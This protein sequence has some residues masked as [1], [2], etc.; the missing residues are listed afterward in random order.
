[1]SEQSPD[2]DRQPWFASKRF[3]YG[4]RPASW[5]GR[6]IIAAFLLIEVGIVSL[7]P[8]FYPSWFK[9]KTTG[10]GFVPATWQGWLTVIGPGLLL[11]AIVSSIT[12]RQ[13]QE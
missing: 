12:H 3:G 9:A 6:L 11:L 4:T 5:Q 13:R 10:S 1:M 8:H 2:N 7:A